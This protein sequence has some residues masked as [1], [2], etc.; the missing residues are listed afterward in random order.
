MPGGL[1]AGTWLFNE[2]LFRG[3]RSEPLRGRKKPDN[4]VYAADI[5]GDPSPKGLRMTLVKSV[6]NL[7]SA[8]NP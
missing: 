1:N 2:E 6:H 5:S 4:S 8:D 7:K 3:V